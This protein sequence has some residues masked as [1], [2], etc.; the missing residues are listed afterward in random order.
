ML[1]NTQVTLHTHNWAR[2][3]LGGLLLASK[4]WD[5]HA[6][7]NI[8]FCQIFPDVDVTDMNELERWYMSAI[9]YNVSIK[10]SL[11]ARYYFE[12]RDLADSQLQSKTSKPLSRNDVTLLTGKLSPR[13]GTGSVLL[14][15]TAFE[16]PLTQQSDSK[17]SGSQSK[18]LTSQGSLKMSSKS[19]TGT[20]DRKMKKS[21]SDYVY[22]PVQP[23]A[24]V[25]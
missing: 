13:Y 8:D 16:L 1:I 17:P 25:I 20:Q 3:V 19:Q 21:H 14:G 18:D 7:W 2:I 15:S 24:Q 23:P 10:A 12:L 22:I 11:Y 9:Q 4:V 5:D 6:V